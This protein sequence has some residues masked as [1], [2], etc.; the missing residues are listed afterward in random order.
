MPFYL[1]NILGYSPRNVGLLMAIVPIV[2][3]FIAPVAGSLSDRYGA[4]PITVIGL[5]LVLGGYFAIGALDEETSALSYVL[6]FLPIGLGMGVFQSPNNSAIMGSVPRAQ[7]GVAGGLLSE[8]RV[9]G[10]TSGI[11]ILGTFWATRVAVRAPGQVGGDATNAPVAA[12]I[13]GLHDMLTFIQVMIALALILC[14]WDL[15]RRRQLSNE[16]IERKPGSADKRTKGGEGT[17]GV[18]VVTAER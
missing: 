13:G 10:Q 9:L 3:V 11:A 16:E 18:E 15:F 5:V 4:R 8:T 1:E 17:S 12:Q 7:S 6:L 2:L 14:V